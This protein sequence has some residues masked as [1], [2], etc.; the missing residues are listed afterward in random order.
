MR[1]RLYDRRK[2]FF[3]TV[4]QQRV[5]GE[6]VRDIDITRL[7]GETFLRSGSCI[8]AVGLSVV[9]YHLRSNGYLPPELGKAVGDKGT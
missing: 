7:N 6:D 3:E 1:L 8:V 9:G 5:D 2:E 4:V